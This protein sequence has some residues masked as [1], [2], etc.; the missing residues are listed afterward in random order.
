MYAYPSISLPA[1]KTDEEYCMA[2][3]EQAGVCVVPG[4]GFGQK[5]GTAHFRTTILPPTRQIEAVIDAI[6]AFQRRWR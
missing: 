2:L 6:D 1:G 3:L 5:P 4:T